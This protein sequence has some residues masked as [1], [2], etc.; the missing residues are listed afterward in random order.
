V[1]DIKS[2]SRPASDRNRWPASYW[3]AWPASSESAAVGVNVNDTSELQA[4]FGGWKLSGVGS[5]LGPEGLMSFRQ[6]KHIKLR[7]RDRQAG[8]S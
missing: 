4:P 3:N 7:V 2:E 8:W 5:E 6:T 1:A